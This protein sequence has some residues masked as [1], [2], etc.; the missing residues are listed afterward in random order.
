MA[1]TAD[2][3]NA[4]SNVL[5]GSSDKLIVVVGPCSIHDTAAALEYASLLA[6][7][8]KNP[9]ISSSL[10]IV[11]RAYLEKPR[12]TIGWKGLL[13]D[14]DLDGTFQINQGLHISR[15][16]FSDITEM[17]IPVASELL[18]VLSPRYLA[19]FMS[20]GAI[21]ARTTE[22]QVHRELA[23]GMPFPVGFKNGTDGN[24]GLAI[25]A[26]ESATSKHYFAGI[27]NHG[28]ATIIE[29]EGNK[30]VFVILRGGGGKTNYDEVS[31]AKAK[32][33]LRKRGRREN[34]MIDCSHGESINLLYVR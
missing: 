30:D 22:S 27:S 24:I 1:T 5:G 12:T 6:N 29:T 28:N 4:I 9:M 3:R 16:L 17:G 34:V 26:Q 13:N 19:E 31:V 2:C 20:L 11:M 23:S 32:E 18:G 25:D 15:K 33:G 7:L 14:P 10:V 8:A 21:G